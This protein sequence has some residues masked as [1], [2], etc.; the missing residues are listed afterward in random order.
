MITNKVHKRGT[1]T[2]AQLDFPEQAKSIT[3]LM[4]NLERSVRAHAR[5][6]GKDRAQVLEKCRGQIQRQLTILGA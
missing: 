5:F 4:N 2:F 1:K 6:P 3:A